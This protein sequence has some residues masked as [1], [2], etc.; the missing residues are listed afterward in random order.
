MDNDFSRWY[1]GYEEK[2]ITDH[3]KKSFHSLRHNFI[4]NLKQEITK[5]KA[6]GLEN[7]LKETVGHAN[8]SITLYR[9]GK[10][11]VLQI[12]LDLIK[13]LDY[14]IDLSHLKFPIAKKKG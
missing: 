9:Y 8:E 6:Y 4:H 12:K 2:Y 10:E 3:P 13:R 11:Y 1:N 5:D 14:G 7:V